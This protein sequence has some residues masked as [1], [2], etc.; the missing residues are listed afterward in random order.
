MRALLL[1]AAMLAACAQ[2][3]RT[4]PSGARAGFECRPGFGAA[5]VSVT[6]DVASVLLFDGAY[7]SGKALIVYQYAPPG[8]DG[9]WVI[10]GRLYDVASASLGPVLTISPVE[11]GHLVP[12]VVATEA[13]FFVA[14]QRDEPQ[15]ALLGRVVGLDGG[16]G[17]V[18]RLPVA[19]ELRL[20]AHAGQAVALTERSV[21]DGSCRLER[22]ILTPQPRPAQLVATASHC[23]TA[24]PTERAGPDG[25]P[26]LTFEAEEAG[27]KRIWLARLSA[28]GRKLEPLHPLIDAR[29][30]DE[31]RATL[32]GGNMLVAWVES[33]PVAGQPMASHIVVGAFDNWGRQ[34]GGRR[35]VAGAA[36]PTDMH[37]HVLGRIGGRDDRA[38]LVWG[39]EGYAQPLDKEGQPSGRAVKLLPQGSVRPQLVATESGSLL[40]WMDRRHARDELFVAPVGC[41]GVV[42]DFPPPGPIVARRAEAPPP[43]AADTTCAGLSFDFAIPPPS[44]QIQRAASPSITA[45]KGEQWTAWQDWRNVR[46]P[47]GLPELF[48]RRMHD[49]VPAGREN[50]LLPASASFDLVTLADGRALV[51]N[52]AK[53]EVQAQLLGESTTGGAVRLSDGLAQVGDVTAVAGA[54]GALAVWIAEQRLLVAREIDAKGGAGVAWTLSSLPELASEPVA[55]AAPGG[56]V[57]AWLEHEDELRVARIVDHRVSWIAAGVA[58]ERLGDGATLEAVGVVGDQVY[59]VSSARILRFAADGARLADLAMPALRPIAASVGANGLTMVTRE[60]AADHETVCVHRL[61]GA[62][63]PL[64]RPAC[65]PLSGVLEPRAPSPLHLRWTG[66]SLY[67]TASEWLAGHGEARILHWRCAAPASAQAIATE[68]HARAEAQ[69]EV[70]RRENQAQTRWPAVLPCATFAGVAAET[71]DGDELTWLADGGARRITTDRL[72]GQPKTE[73][74]IDAKIATDRPAWLTWRYPSPPQGS[75]RLSCGGKGA[76][77]VEWRCDGT[78]PRGCNVEAHYPR[79]GSAPSGV[80]GRDCP[81]RYKARERQTPVVRAAALLGDALALVDRVCAGGRCSTRVAEIAERLR[82]AR[83]EKHWQVAPVFPPRE[84]KLTA[85]GGLQLE[86]SCNADAAGSNGCM[87]ELGSGIAFQEEEGASSCAVGGENLLAPDGLNFLREDASG[88]TVAGDTLR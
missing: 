20:V 55:A 2:P 43:R 46:D 18:T 69:A 14:W 8:S 38:L 58:L 28:E 3:P 71:S 7:K 72:S 64:D 84:M 17:E 48:V 85:R 31:P 66:N 51:V 26:W 9:R 83:A 42:P 62:A 70:T 59:V 45:Q 1:S 76:G 32:L 24:H 41:G 68:A 12:Q 52:A 57:V 56:F 47:N 78:G 15:H 81:D 67:A 79:P 25:A 74:P 13:G 16:L 11:G 39:Y 23:L 36:S 49:R 29:V 19:G 88:F 37:D 33:S 54:D 5:A 82:A 44:T 73:R 65:V 87:L 6:P 53:R 63:K 22:T 40:L 60:R 10:G 75:V 80:R 35:P 34:L 50:R 30:W 27:A 61:D 77:S 4:G 21:K 86:L